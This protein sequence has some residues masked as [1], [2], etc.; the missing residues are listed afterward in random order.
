MKRVCIL[1]LSAILLCCAGCG[2]SRETVVTPPSRIGTERVEVA[3]IQLP[4]YSLEDAYRASTAV[5][6]VKVGNWLGGTED[7]GDLHFTYY[8]VSTVK[9]FKGDLPEKFVLVQYGDTK[10]T[11]ID[12]PLYTS[13]DELLVFLTP[14]GFY[15]E[16]ENVSRENT[17]RLL[18]DFASVLNAAFDKAGNVYYIDSYGSLG[19]FTDLPRQNSN[20]KVF[21]AVREDLTARDSVIAQTAFQ[22]PF[23]I[24]SGVDV[25]QLFMSIVE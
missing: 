17:Y 13:G 15:D 25:E 19:R 5:A 23:Y 16:P 24:Y 11:W 9:S 6:H 12:Y 1:L 2:A 4:G 20:D 10:V 3:K 22:Y 7:H 21:N 14:Y 18:N 8:E